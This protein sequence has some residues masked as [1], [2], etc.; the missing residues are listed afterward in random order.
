MCRSCGALN[1][2]DNKFCGQCASPLVDLGSTS[3]REAAAPQSPTPPTAEFK[4]VTVLFCDIVNSTGLAE[5]LGAEALHEL[6]RRFLDTGIAEVRRYGGTV[7]QFTGDGF[8]ALFG[9]PVAHEDHVRRALLTAVAIRRAIGGSPGSLA[10]QDADAV[11]IRIGINTGLVVFGAVADKLRMDFTAVGD[12]ANIAARLQ[13]A[14]EPGNIV[15]S[16]ATFELARG[17]VLAEP[18]GALSLK[19]KTEPIS[20]LRLIEVL[21]GRNAFDEIASVGSRVFVG[22]ERE[23]AILDQLLRHAEQGDGQAAGI[24]GQP[25]IGK[26]RLITEFHRSLAGRLIN[27]IEGR[28]VSYGTEIPY[29]LLLDLLRSFCRIVDSDTPSAIAAKVRAGLRKVGLDPETDSGLLLDLLGIGGASPETSQNDPGAVKIKAFTIFRQFFVNASQRQLLVL[30]VEDLHWVDKISEEFLAFLAET[31]PGG[32]IL[33]LVTYRPGYRP[34]WI[35]KSYAAQI[36]LHPLNP[37]ESQ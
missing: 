18:I 32:P 9:A 1:S 17:Y 13:Q 37:E 28:C 15:I 12:A 26:S 11:P 35:D 23:L 20:A 36:P 19:G 25:G 33:L 34:P 7:P 24:L 8:M 14:A 22:R 4:Q 29:L 6:L 3:P 16:E 30:A 31:L 27:W 21:S 5:R 10:G 2:P